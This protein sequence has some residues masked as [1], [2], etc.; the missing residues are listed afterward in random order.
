MS[1]DRYLSFGGVPVRYQ[2]HHPLKDIKNRVALIASPLFSIE[3]YN[4]ILPSLLE[5][6]NLCVVCDFPGFG[7]AS[8]SKA[9]TMEEAAKMIWGILDEVDRIEGGRLCCWHL[10]GHGL[11][12][13]TAYDMARHSPDGAASLV[14]LCPCFEIGRMFRTPTLARILFRLASGRRQFARAAR[15]LYGKKLPEKE[16]MPLRRAFNRPKVQEKLRYLLAKDPQRQ[17][18]ALFV[19]QMILWC[20]RDG[21]LGG[22]IPDSLKKLLP[23]GEYHTLP[24]AGH[25]PM[26]THAGAVRDYVRGWLASNGS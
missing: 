3:Q 13:R 23:D 14:L 21:I 2:V 7:P 15:F 8:S 9:V 11:S 17:P 18:A 5:K 22:Q 25:V 4:R 6:G 26:Y 20:G 12:A 16:W 10:V 19:P 24:T 1:L